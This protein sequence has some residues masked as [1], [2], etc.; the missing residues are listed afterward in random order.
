MMC[1]DTQK[2]KLPASVP[3]RIPLLAQTVVSTARVVLA[4]VEVGRSI[5][6]AAEGGVV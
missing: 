5:S 3:D 2:P 4:V 6:D 1:E